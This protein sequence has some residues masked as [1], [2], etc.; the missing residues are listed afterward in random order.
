MH[1]QVNTKCYPEASAS[2]DLHM[3]SGAKF[4]VAASNCL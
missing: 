4:E 2:C 1:L 3:Y